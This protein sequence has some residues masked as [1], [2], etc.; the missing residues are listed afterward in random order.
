[1]KLNLNK[2]FEM[3]HAI[4]EKEKDRMVGTYTTAIPV[5][6]WPGNKNHF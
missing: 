3:P 4:V 1:M 2:V 6:H 5:K